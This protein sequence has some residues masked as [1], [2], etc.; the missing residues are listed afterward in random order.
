MASARHGGGRGSIIPSSEAKC[1]SLCP[2]NIAGK[3]GHPEGVGTGLRW[4]AP[5]GF[6]WPAGKRAKHQ[7]GNGGEQRLG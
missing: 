4:A 1:S 7:S 2:S 6:G 5:V 3:V